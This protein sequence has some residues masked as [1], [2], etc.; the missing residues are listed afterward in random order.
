MT[1]HDVTNSL[2]SHLR[3]FVK[4]QDYDDYTPRDQAV[5]RFVMK[6]LTRQLADSMSCATEATSAGS[7]PRGLD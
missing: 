5:W 4:T 6:H 1:Q 3:P 7:A 2:P